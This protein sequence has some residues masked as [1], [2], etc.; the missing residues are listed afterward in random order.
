MW[1]VGTAAKGLTPY[2]VVL[3]WCSCGVFQFIH[4]TVTLF[5]PAEGQGM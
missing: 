3:F 1:D 5:W 2:T 4:V